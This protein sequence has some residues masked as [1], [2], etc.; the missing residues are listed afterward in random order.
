MAVYHPH[1]TAQIVDLGT[2]LSLSVKEAT[3]FVLEIETGGRLQVWHTVTGLQSCSQEMK[4]VG[5][6]PSG[7]AVKFAH[8]TSAARGSLVLIPRVDLC[9]AYKP[10]CGRNPTYK[11]EEDGHGC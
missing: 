6:W 5:G 8:S 4:T 3:L 10:C 7:A 2:P 11:I 9:A 1:S